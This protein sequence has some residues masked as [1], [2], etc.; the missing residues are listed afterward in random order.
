M[1]QDIVDAIYEAAF[2]PEMWPKVLSE[3]SRLSGSAS[4]TFFVF[5]D[6]APVRGKIGHAPSLDVAVADLLGQYFEEFVA[7]DSWKTSAV[8]LGMYHMQPASFV[9]VE[10]FMTPEQ[11]ERDPVRIRLRATGIGAHLCAAIPVPSGELITMVFQ[12]RLQDGPHDD[13]AVAE[14]DRIQPHFAR[15]GLI[16]ARLGLARAEATVS[17]LEML[18][19][20][21]AVLDR[22]GRVVASNSLFETI[23]TRLRPAAFGTIA[24]PDAATNALFQEALAQAGEAA[25]QRIGSVPIAA[26]REHPAMVVHVLPLRGAAHDIFSGGDIVVAA[27]AVNPSALVPDASILMGLFDLTPAEV[28]LASALTRGLSLK[29]AAVEAGIAFST[30]RSYLERIFAKTG[31]HQQ[32]QLVALLK[33]AASFR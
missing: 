17:T 15:A 5:G 26:E 12:R 6:H 23:G 11:I 33:G 30:A 22:R 8:I 7:G 20:P 25:A 14:L 16:A 31:V 3:T 28:K 21:A 1:D 18:G 19:L 4:G 32:S 2:V 10:A 9:H 29:A 27:T 24:L 13:A